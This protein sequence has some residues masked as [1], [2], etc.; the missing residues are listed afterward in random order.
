MR[1]KNESVGT[2]IFTLFISGVLYSQHDRNILDEI[3]PTPQMYSRV[4][5]MSNPTELQFDT[6]W[7][8]TQN[9]DK[10]NV[11]TTLKLAEHAVSITQKTKTRT[12][13]FHHNTGYI[14]RAI[15]IIQL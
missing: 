12:H 9:Y 1:I 5:Q 6:I 4:M 8:V 3:P 2:L 14:A 13:L 7:A 15:K 11:D 10:I